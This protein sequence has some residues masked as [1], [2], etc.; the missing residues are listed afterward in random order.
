MALDGD[1]GGDLIVWTVVDPEQAQG[2]VTC[3]AGFGPDALFTATHPGRT[4]VRALAVDP[5]SL[6]LQ[7]WVET[8]VWVAG[9]ALAEAGLPD[10]M[11]E[12]IEAAGFGEVAGIDPT[13]FIDWDEVAGIDPT[14]FTP[15]SDQDEVSG[16]DPTPFHGARSYPE[17]AASLSTGCLLDADAS[18]DG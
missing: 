5:E 13:P 6:A 12:V 9:E 10:P 7:S 11:A 18:S 15:L 17:L 4:V 16:I 2:P 1:F 3:V 8:E 14:P